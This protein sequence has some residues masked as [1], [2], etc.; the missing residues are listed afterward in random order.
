MRGGRTAAVSAGGVVAGGGVRASG[1]R[2]ASEAR[3]AG[4]PRSSE[5][6]LS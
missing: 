3:V 2:G 1:G 4:L 5:T 6:S